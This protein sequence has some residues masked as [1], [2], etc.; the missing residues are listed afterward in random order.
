MR[1]QKIVEAL[2]LAP[3]NDCTASVLLP[4]TKISLY[5]LNTS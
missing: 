3:V 5:R 1:P 4:S 2:R